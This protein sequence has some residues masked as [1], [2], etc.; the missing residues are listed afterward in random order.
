MSPTLRLT[1]S[2]PASLLVNAQ[3]IVAL[4][5]EDGSGSFGILP[6][7]ADFLTVL[8]PCVLRWRGTENIRRFCAVEEGVLRVSEGHSVTIACRSGMLGDSLAALE[9]QI[10]TA[11]AR[12]LDTARNARVE[13]TRLHAQAVRQLLRYLRPSRGDA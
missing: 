10:E 7:H 5:A 12:T 3:A 11:R 13:Q 8:T 2:T 9:A 1:I 6:G 4:R